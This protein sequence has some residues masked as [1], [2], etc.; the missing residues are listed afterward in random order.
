[1][2]TVSRSDESRTLGQLVGS[3]VKESRLYEH[4]LRV[5]RTV[6]RRTGEERRPASC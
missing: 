3:F 4:P 2:G 6:Q 5:L 1:M